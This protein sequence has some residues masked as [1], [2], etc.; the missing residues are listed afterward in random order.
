MIS[1]PQPPSPTPV[2]AESKVRRKVYANVDEQPLMD[3]HPS[4]ALEKVQAQ[5]IR[6][7]QDGREG[8]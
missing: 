2:L 6:K 3:P 8:S 5:R 1:P 7:A 4:S